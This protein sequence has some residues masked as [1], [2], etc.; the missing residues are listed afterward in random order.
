[1]RWTILLLVFAIGCG[2]KGPP[3]SDLELNKV[4]KL[5]ELEGCTMYQFTP[6]LMDV[7]YFVLCP[8]TVGQVT[9]RS[10]WI[11]SDG[12]SHSDDK[13]VPTIRGSCPCSEK[14]NDAR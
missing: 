9:T 14:P 12:V 1:M 6:Y 13:V 2:E 4:E 3:K 7:Q 5:F 11:D 10:T 8:N